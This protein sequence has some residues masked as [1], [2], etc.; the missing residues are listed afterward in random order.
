MAFRK[1][2]KFDFKVED[3]KGITILIRFDK[4]LTGAKDNLN[5]LY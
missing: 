4:I 5:L 1:L 2:L 3:E